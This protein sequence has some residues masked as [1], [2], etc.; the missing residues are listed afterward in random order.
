MGVNVVDYSNAW[1]WV[2]YARGLVITA[3]PYLL[4][5]VALGG[6]FSFVVRKLRRGVG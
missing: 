1:E 3:V 6:A 2:A 4:G 5:I